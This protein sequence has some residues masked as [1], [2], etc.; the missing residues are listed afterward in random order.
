MLKKH[1]LL[2]IAENLSLD[3][4]MHP[5]LIKLFIYFKKIMNDPKL[6]QPSV[7]IATDLL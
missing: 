3:N 7:C 1:L 5:C 6:L 2:G 4:L